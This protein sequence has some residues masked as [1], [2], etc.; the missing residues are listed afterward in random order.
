MPA[1]EARINTDRARRISRPDELAITWQPAESAPAA[2]RRDDLL[3]AL[4]APGG[5]SNPFPLYAAAH[6]IGPV[7]QASDQLFVACGQAWIGNRPAP[8][9]VPGGSGHGT[10]WWRLVVRR[11]R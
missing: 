3:G 2:P 5:R 4:L 10:G 1:S 7:F 9:V 8:V 11:S 6:K